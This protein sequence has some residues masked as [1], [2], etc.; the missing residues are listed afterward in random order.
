[1]NDTNYNDYRSQLNTLYYFFTGT[2]LFADAKHQEETNWYANT[3]TKNTFEK[4][5]NQQ[6]KKVEFKNGGYATFRD[7]NTF[8][9]IKCSQYKD[10]PTQ[11][12]NLHLDLWYDGKNIMQDNGSYKYNA[13][14]EDTKYFMGTASHNTVMLGDNDQMEKGGRFI[15]YYWNKESKFISS[16]NE[17]EFIFEGK[18]KAFEQV[19]KNI[20]HK[21]KVT[22]IKAQPLWKVEDEM[23]HNTNL[24]MNQIWHPTDFFFANFE[25]K[26]LD[27]NGFE[28]LP[29]IKDAYHSCYYG[30]K[31]KTKCIIF[32]TSTKKITTEIVSKQNHN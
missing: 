32:S 31:E 28:I 8:T 15:W 19:G 23:Q 27:E 6:S 20:F 17:I 30:I 24:P 3:F 12:D 5:S 9:F 4:I 22:K 29:T 21:R 10:R 26:A 7:A 16:E 14:L 11:A 2:H 18:I 25:I 13:S 1:M